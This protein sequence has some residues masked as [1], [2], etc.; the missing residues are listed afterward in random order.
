MSI[1]DRLKKTPAPK[2]ASAPKAKKTEDATA[3][4]ADTSASSEP[5][6]TAAAGTV[7]KEFAFT[8]VK[9]HVS[10]KA[11]RLADKGIYVFDVPVTVNKV[12]IRK[13]V[14]SQYKVNVIKV[15]T[16]RS[17]GKPVLRG[18]IAGRRNRWKKA[19]V[20]LKKGQT[21]N[22]VEGV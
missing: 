12:E 7:S 10:E 13:A 8:L 1:L 9:P 15:R 19:M 11:A 6:V 17:I 3:V 5:K 20:E 16:I 14:E 22:L 4:A 18:K 2:K 21:L